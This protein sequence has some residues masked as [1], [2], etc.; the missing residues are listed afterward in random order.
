[1]I[2]DRKVSSTDSSTF[3][4][5]DKLLNDV[6]WMVV[7]SSGVA[8]LFDKFRERIGAYVA[9]N[10]NTPNLTYENVVIEIEKITRE[11]NQTYREVLRGNYF[12][13]LIGIKSTTATNLLHVHPFGFAENV[14]RY[15]A[16]GHGEPYGSLYLKKLWHK[17]M[18]MEEVAGLGFFIIRSIEVNELDDSVG[19]GEEGK[20]QIFFIP[21]QPIP[22]GTPP[23]EWPKYNPKQVDEELLRHLEEQTKERLQYQRKSLMELLR[24]RPAPSA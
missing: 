10:T 15:K 13:V 19:V 24:A 8:G 18:T 12:D 7:G 1:M 14:R 21:N 2:A 3:D 22:A 23:E 11:L 6:A 17:S 5:E 16:I 4:Y 20:P 9:T